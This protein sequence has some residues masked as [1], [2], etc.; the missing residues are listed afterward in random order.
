[1]IEEV[2]FVIHTID[3]ILSSTGVS[4]LHAIEGGEMTGSTAILAQRS[5]VL[6]LLVGLKQHLKV[7]YSLTEAKCRAFDPKKAGG[8]KD[9]KTAVRTRAPGVIEWSEIPYVEKSTRR[10]AGAGTVTSGTSIFDN[11][12]IV[13]GIDASR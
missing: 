3:R 10:L 9:N 5:I 12:T 4:L 11:L 7:A 13:Y 6:S 1:M 2:F 8:A